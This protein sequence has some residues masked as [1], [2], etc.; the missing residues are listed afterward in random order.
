MPAPAHVEQLMIDLQRTAKAFAAMRN[1]AP[2]LHPGVENASITLL[3]KLTAEPLRVGELADRVHSDIST[4]SRQVSYL[5]QSGLVEKTPDPD[6]RR[7][8]VLALTDRGR[9]LA[10][11]LRQQ[12]CQLLVEVLR[13]W[14]DEK[15]EGVSAAM[16]E[17]A[18]AIE[19]AVHDD[20]LRRRLPPPITL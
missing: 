9:E 6:D 10:R 19:T 3:F 17:F 8:Q 15:V 11:R 1:V 18:D 12:R 13:D 7:A 5:V 20:D 4:V 2:V 14:P 16:R